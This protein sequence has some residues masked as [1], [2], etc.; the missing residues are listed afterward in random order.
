MEA[1]VSW[2]MELQGG[3]TLNLSNLLISVSWPCTTFY[4]RKAFN[5]LPSRWA[6]RLLPNQSTQCQACRASLLGPVG[7]VSLH[8]SA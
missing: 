4:V 8:S 3:I 7:E 2:H 1:F 6:F 5:Q